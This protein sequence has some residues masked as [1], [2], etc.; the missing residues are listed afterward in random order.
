[1]CFE[2]EGLLNLRRTRHHAEPTIYELVGFVA[3][4]DSAEQQKSHLVSVVN[5]E[6]L[7]TQE[8]HCGIDIV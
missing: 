4:I 5:G 8:Y 2:G 7:Q 6:K 3:D 1:M